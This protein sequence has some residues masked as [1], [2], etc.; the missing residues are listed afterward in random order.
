VGIALLFAHQ[1]PSLVREP[2]RLTCSDSGSETGPEHK[3]GAC[4]LW[5]DPVG[6]GRPAERRS[7]SSFVVPT[8][9]VLAVGRRPGHDRQEA[10]QPVDQICGV[11][12]GPVWSGESTGRTR[13]HIVVSGNSPPLP[14]VDA[15]T[16]HSD[17]RPVPRRRCRGSRWPTPGSARGS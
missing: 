11:R 15:R 14:A 3:L 2:S 12:I 13:C 10:A 4:L 5:C 8:C 1:W 17:G 7:S 9:R 6:L 16:R